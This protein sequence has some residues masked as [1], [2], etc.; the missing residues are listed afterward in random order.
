[1]WIPCK[2]TIFNSSGGS[3][4][5]ISLRLL[6]CF[7]RI[8]RYSKPEIK[9]LLSFC[10]IS[11]HSLPPSFPLSNVLQISLPADQ[12]LS[13]KEELWSKNRL[14]IH[15]PPFYDSFTWKHTFSFSL[16]PSQPS[17]GWSPNDNA[18]FCGAIPLPA[19]QQSRSRW[20]DSDA[21]HV[22]HLM[23]A[24]SPS[25]HAGARLKML[26][27]VTKGVHRHVLG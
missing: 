21:E 11:F 5:L 15:F 9:R 7:S 12:S 10:F 4:T 2:E 18:S 8:I 23:A 17:K 16:F 3:C 20:S 6:H 24:G 27:S 13:Y 1:M 26:W 25:S 19:A 22:H 14:A